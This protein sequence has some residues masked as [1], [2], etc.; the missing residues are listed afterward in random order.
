M[1]IGATIDTG[2]A[3]IKWPVA[4][5]ALLLLPGSALAFEVVIAAIGARHAPR[6]GGGAPLAWVAEP[7]DQP[8]AGHCSPSSLPREKKNPL[9]HTPYIYS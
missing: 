8:F 7:F 6:T 5:T 3:I 1:G 4:I 2:L 9:L